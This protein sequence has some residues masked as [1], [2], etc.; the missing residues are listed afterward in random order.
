VEIPRD[1]ALQLSAMR[2]GRDGAVVVRL[3]NPR[4]SESAAT[5]RFARPVREARAVD[6][7][8]GETGLGNTGLDV[9]RTAAPPEV[10]DGAL[11]VRL[12][13]YE[14]GTFEVQLVA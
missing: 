12:Q 6:L 2:A 5:L 14:I 9:I 10:R 13:G 1:S 11:A 3:F 7:R 4:G 8:E